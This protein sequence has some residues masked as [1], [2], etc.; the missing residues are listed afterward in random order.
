M[1]EK[2]ASMADNKGKLDEHTAEELKVLDTSLAQMR[3]RHFPRIATKDL[4]AVVYHYTNDEGLKGILQSSQLWFTSI[5][6][7]NDPSELTR[8]M[9]AGQDL[10]IGALGHRGSKIRKFI[11]DRPLDAAYLKSTRFFTCS[12]STDSDELGQWRSYADDG[13]GFA[14][15]F[16]SKNLLQDQNTITYP[17]KYD[18]KSFNETARDLIAI[19]IPFLLK[20]EGSGVDVAR[21]A[22]S[23]Y[24]SLLAS[25]TMAAILHKHEDYKQESEVRSI[26]RAKQGFQYRMRPYD[27]VQYVPYHYGDTQIIREIVVGPSQRE[28]SAAFVRDCLSAFYKHKVEIRFSDIPYRPSR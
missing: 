19:A 12:F 11:E 28:R 13:R 15:G 17:V 2:I 22:V 25:L 21:P 26:V 3:E 7:L 6:N 24:A 4:Q 10:L 5:F 23:G 20:H 8:G 27:L 16:E 14:I 1:I 18:D 9:Q